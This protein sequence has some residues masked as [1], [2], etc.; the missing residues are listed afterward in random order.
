MS[1]QDDPWIYHERQEARLCGLH[2]LNNLAQISNC[3]AADYLASIAHE[4]AAMELSMYDAEERRIRIREGSHYVDDSGNFSIEVLKVAIEQKLG[5][6]LV[7]TVQNQQEITTFQGFLCHKSDHWFAIRNIGGRFWN[8]NST[9]ERPALVSHFTLGSEM[10]HCREQGYTVFLIQSGLPEGG[11]KMPHGVGLWHKMSDLLKGRSSQ[12]DPWE[13]LTGKGQ[14]LDGSSSTGTGQGAK[15]DIDSL[16]EEE[17][18]QMALEQSLAPPGQQVVVP[19]EPPHDA[20]NAVRIQFRLPAKP[21]VV[22]RFFDTDTV[23]GIYA[24]CES[25][26]EARAV[27]LQYGFPPKDLAS[28]RDKTIAEASLANETIQ[29]RNV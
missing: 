4:L 21:R 11:V 12:P 23:A 5:V 9:L 20:T 24:F 15:R 26:N 6:A 27:H 1:T 16:T 3:F 2:A 28:L 19:P 22:R 25:V 29:G 10:E 13:N 7:A 17:L 14:R 18:L 8:L